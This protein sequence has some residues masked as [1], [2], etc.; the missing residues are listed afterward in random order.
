MLMETATGEAGQSR[1][2]V[3]GAV[4]AAAANRSRYSVIPSLR[5]TNRITSTYH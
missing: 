4:A 3:R 1:G 2:V 5:F